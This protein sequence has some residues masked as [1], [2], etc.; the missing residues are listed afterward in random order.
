MRTALH[1]IFFSLFF[2]LLNSCITIGGSKDPMPAKNIEF[3]APAGSFSNLKTESGD[4]SWISSKTNNIISYISDCSPLQDPSLEQ[5]EQE[6]LFGLEKIEIKHREDLSYNH[7]IARNTIAEA[8]VDGV[9]I[10]IEVISFKKNN[11]NYNLVYGG[12]AD[13]FE[14][15]AAEFK[16]FKDNFKAP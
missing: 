1:S 4:K 14:S 2:L 15:E 6:A 16:L 13:R 3:T 7:R 10:K 12:T 8:L 5:L 9:K 11:C